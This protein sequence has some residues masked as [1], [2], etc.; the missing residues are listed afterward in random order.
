MQ[1]HL[2]GSHRNARIDQVEVMVEVVGM[3]EAEAEVEVV[4]E[5]G[6]M[7]EADM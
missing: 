2:G 3:V 7:V 1:T 5:V 4:L 6:A